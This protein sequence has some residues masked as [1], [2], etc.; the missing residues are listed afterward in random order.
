ME[1]ANHLDIGIDFSLEGSIAVLILHVLLHS[2]VKSSE[3]FFLNSPVMFEITSK[4]L[5]QVLQNTWMRS[6]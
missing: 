3:D 1:T 5:A 4:N 6:H 2:G